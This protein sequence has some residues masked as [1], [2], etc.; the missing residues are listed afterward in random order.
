MARLRTGSGAICCVRLV[1]RWKILLPTKTMIAWDRT[2]LSCSAVTTT[3][4]SDAAPIK[5]DRRIPNSRF[6]LVT[7]A[8]RGGH[9]R[10]RREVRGG[11]SGLRWPRK[12]PHLGLGLGI[13]E[14]AEL[15][16]NAAGDRRRFAA[17]L[18]AGEVRPV[19]PRDGTAQPNAGLDRGVMDD[20]DRALVV[21]GALS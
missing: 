3:G 16:R 11:Y 10:T 20:I 9:W 4:I 12:R 21:G 8:H 14:G 15:R 13:G 18:E 19:T 5:P 2:V 7:S 1:Q 6:R 17:G